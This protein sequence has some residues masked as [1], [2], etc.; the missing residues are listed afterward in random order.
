MGILPL[1]A[2]LNASPTAVFDIEGREAAVQTR[3]LSEYLRGRLAAQGLQILPSSDLTRALAGLKKTSLDPCYDSAC[4][5]ELGKEVAAQR[6]LATRLRRVS[7]ECLLISTV[8]DLTTELIDQAATWKG[9]CTQD[10][11]VTGL[12]QLATSLATSPGDPESKRVFAAFPIAPRT[13]SQGLAGT[14]DEYVVA[15]LA[16]S[17]RRVVPEP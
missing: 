12:D 2:A 13:I 16:L 5:I 3:E 4:Q 17:G 9:A 10:G 14:I 11:L 15:R 7:E 6:I 8:V 1:L